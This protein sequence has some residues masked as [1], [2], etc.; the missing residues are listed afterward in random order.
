M[1]GQATSKLMDY[2]S[3]IEEMISTINAHA[4]SYAGG[5]EIDYR[6][7]KAMRIIPQHNFV[8][9]GREEGSVASPHR[10]VRFEHTRATRRERQ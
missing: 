3:Q 5:K 6:V 1:E 9:V 8:P 10:H 7:I 4:T 2:K